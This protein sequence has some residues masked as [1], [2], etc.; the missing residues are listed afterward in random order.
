MKYLDEYRDPKI[1]AALL[2][3]IRRIATRTWTIMEICGGQTHSFLRYGLDAMLPAEIQLVHGPGCPVCVTPLEQIDRAI[4]IASRE[5]VIFTSF[6]DMLRVPGSQSDLFGVRAHGGDVRVVYSPLEAVTLAEAHPEKQVVFFAIGFET[7][8][9][10]NA[11]SVLQAKDRGIK[12]FSVLVS[13]VRVPPAIEAILSSPR[14]RVQAFLAAGHVCTVMGFWEYE[15]LAEKFHVPIVVT[16]FEPVDLLAGMLAAV[17]QLEAERHVVEN[18]YT[19]LVSRG[20]NRTAQETIARVFMDCDRAWRGIGVIP[21]SGWRLRDELADF[22]AEKRF[23]VGMITP[24]E[25]P[26]CIAGE[27][28]QGIKT[29]EECPAFGK[30]C[31]PQNPLGAPMVSAEGACSAY[32]RY[33]T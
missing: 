11:M 17:K 19:R 23:D 22:D 13:H 20:G 21:H 2:E 18:A 7:T 9:P 6:G 26:L 4:A 1:T 33:R 29:P 3:E 12:N 8:A 14:N 25:S 24:K 28:L 31:T 30:E 27:V 32:F 15:P 16:G 5:D 10:P